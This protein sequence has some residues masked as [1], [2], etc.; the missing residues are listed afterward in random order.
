MAKMNWTRVGVETRGQKHGYERIPDT[1]AALQATKKRKKTT[2]KHAPKVLAP[3]RLSRF[4][5]PP[6]LPLPERKSLYEQLK[7]AER[8]EQKSKKS[9][10]VPRDNVKQLKRQK[11]KAARRKFKA[12]GAELL[13]ATEE[14]LRAR[15]ERMK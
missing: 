12:K 7:D 2:V 8:A 5:L 6:N 11:K 14:E 1:I 3:E 10:P 13:H 4:R 9:P 15:K